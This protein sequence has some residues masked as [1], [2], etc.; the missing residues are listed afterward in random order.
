MDPQQFQLF[1][2]QLTKISSRL[3]SIYN[4]LPESEDKK[5]KDK[6]KA[7]RL[8]PRE[9]ERIKEIAKI[10]S[11]EFDKSFTKLSKKQEELNDENEK[12]FQKNG[13][14]V[15]L[16]SGILVDKLD[17]PID[18]IKLRENEI[19]R[20]DETI[21]KLNEMSTSNQVVLQ[22]EHTHSNKSAE[23]R[24]MSRVLM[25]AMALTVAAVIALIVLMVAFGFIIAFIFEK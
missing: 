15:K 22:Q 6:D 8:Q 7:E 24:K 11:K 12:L 20:L 1:L 5:D 23:K 21:V 13:I 19:K 16:E 4:T 2:D 17:T 18:V 9:K 10:Y 25:L 14:K 3:D